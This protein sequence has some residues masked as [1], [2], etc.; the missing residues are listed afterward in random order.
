M[1]PCTG[2][3]GAEYHRFQ[4]GQADGHGDECTAAGRS[5]EQQRQEGDLADGGHHRSVFMDVRSQRDDGFGD[6]AP[7]ARV[8]DAPDGGGHRDGAAGGGDSG[9]RCRPQVLPEGFQPVF[10]ASKED[11]QAVDQRE[12][13]DR[14]HQ[15]NHQDAHVTA[16]QVRP[17]SGQGAGEPASESDG[18][19]IHQQFHHLSG[20]FRPGVQG[21][22]YAFAFFAGHGGAAAQQDGED[23]EGQQVFFREEHREVRH[24]KGLDEGFSQRSVT[25]FRDLPGRVGKELRRCAVQRIADGDGG[26][27]ETRCDDGHAQEDQQGA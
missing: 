13:E 2:G 12:D 11:I 10:P 16:H 14:Q 8:A 6:L 3:D 20:Y 18:S 21:A 23:D 17:D 27:R 4:Q 24:G 25:V 5:G 7:D 1:F 15:V 19:G 9:H 26:E 22:G